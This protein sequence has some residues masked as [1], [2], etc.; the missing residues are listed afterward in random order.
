MA[1]IA[2][3]SATDAFNVT[4]RFVPLTF[5]VTDGGLNLTAPSSA[6]LAPPGAYLLFLVSTSG[7][8]SAA[9]IVN[10]H[11]GT[12]P[13]APVNL[14]AT[15]AA[16]SVSLAWEMPAGSPPITRYT[17]YRSTTS[18]FT[19]GPSNAVGQSVTTSYAD[20]A[21]TDGTYYYRVAAQDSSGAQGP[22]S[23]EA[24]ATVTQ[25]SGTVFGVDQTVFADG[26]GPRTTA[27]FNTTGSG[28]LLLA[29]VASDG[30]G[31]QTITVSGAGLTWSLVKRVNTQAGTSEM[32]SIRAESV[33]QRD[34]HGDAGLTGI[35]RI[36][37][38][39]GLHGRDGW[40]VRRSQRVERSPDGLADHDATGV[41]GVRRGQRLGP[42]RR[43]C[44]G[45]GADA[46][47]PGPR[48]FRRYL[49]V[50][51]TAAMPAAGT[52]V[53]V[54]DTAPTTDRWNLAAIE[55]VPAGPPPQV[56]VPDVTNRTQSDA[57][58]TL[59]AAGLRI[60]TVTQQPST[61]IAAGLVISQNPAA[62]RPGAGRKR[63]RSGRV[64]RPAAR[65][66]PE[67]IGTHAIGRRRRARTGRSDARAVST[68][69]SATVAAGLVITENPAAGTL[70]SPGT[71]VAIV[72]SSGPSVGPTPD[73]TVSS[74]GTGTRT[75]AASARH[76]RMK[77]SSRSSRPT[78]RRRRRRR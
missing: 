7:I 37:D 68:A 10:V 55:V 57:A 67:R 61:T 42:S 58:A 54:S 44:A 63:G 40:R 15:A 12:A 69:P 46:G 43:A 34:C 17:V 11:P 1:L 20:G 76:R 22:P 32:E 53:Q 23:S 49:W 6:T 64:V 5:Q 9:A 8:P 38:G 24:S 29:F 19:P 72:L 39:C 18:G 25:Q 62:Q 26:A 2:A 28:E 77:C 47:A 21:L 51:A 56:V 14:R 71:S 27:P 30:S 65:R 59:T 74:D 78:A 52:L 4:Q 33:D 60:G 16:S 35:R 31:T 45:C 70:V 73:K 66:R 36:P 48:V 13:P 41:G 50:Q 75:T 3:G